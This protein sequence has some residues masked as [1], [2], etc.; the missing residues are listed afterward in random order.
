MFPGF[1]IFGRFIAS[2]AVAA[3]IGIFT[4]SPFAVL[5]YKKRG[6]NDIEMIL[7]LL[8]SSIGIFLGMHLLYGVVNIPYWYILTEAEGFVDFFKKFYAIFGGSVFYGGLIGGIIAG[9]I[10]I[11][12]RKLPLGLTSDCA[13][14][15]IA[16]FHFF[17]RTGCFLGGCCYGIEWEYG[18]TF[19]NSVIPQAN[20]VP[21]V[22]VQL[23]EAA[24]ELALFLVL[25]L[26]LSKKWF[27]GRLLTI[28]LISYSTGRFFLE[29]LRGDEYR[30][31]LFG[32]STSQ[33][34]SLIVFAVSF[35][36]LIIVGRHK[37]K[38]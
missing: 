3:I 25:W 10:Y 6:G 36:M 33:I 19:H 23:I 15:A 12:I 26:M 13:A 7:M 38:S 37:S 35:P 17:G 18:I 11:K 31:F 24:F 32:F 2:Y 28:Y 30:G 8:V 16:L 34:I 29:Y 1:Y 20:G 27:S 14:P 9:G 5:Q 21:R 4:A 22:P